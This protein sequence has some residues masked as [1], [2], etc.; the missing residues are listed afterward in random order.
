MVG[1]EMA[2]LLVPFLVVA[3][4]LLFKGDLS[5]LLYSPYWSVASS[6]FVGQ[7][8]VR[9]VAHL[10]QSRAHDAGISWEKVVLTFSLLIVLGLVPCLLVLLL[11]LITNTPSIYLGIAQIG[12]FVIAFFL[13]L[14][15][16][17]TIQEMTSEGAHG[18]EVIPAAEVPAMAQ[19]LR[20]G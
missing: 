15:F 5:G 17:Q 8:L 13:Y 3:I 4:G 11:V 14:I 9:C 2:F 20:A 18:T 6:L 19:K 10:V 7:L 12:L 1:T 16:G